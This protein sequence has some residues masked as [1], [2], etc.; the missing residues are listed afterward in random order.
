IAG[1]GACAGT[2]DTQGGEPEIVGQRAEL[3]FKKKEWLKTYDENCDVCFQ[4]F[5]LCQRGAQD[6]AT[7]DACQVALDSCVR[8]GLVKDDGEDDNV[9]QGDEDADAGVDDDDG[10]D[11]DLVGDDDE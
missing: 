7:S 9:D 2:M 8:G 3:V 10:V 11:V 6:E 4:A 5:E 1:L